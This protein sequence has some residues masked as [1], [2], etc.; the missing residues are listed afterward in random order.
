MRDENATPLAGGG[1]MGWLHKRGQYNAA[2]KLRYV[3]LY[4]GTL[5]YFVGKL[6]N[7]RGAV[8]TNDIVDVHQYHEKAQKG[9]DEAPGSSNK[10]QKQKGAAFLVETRHG[11]VYRFFAD[12]RATCD[13]WVQAIQS[14]VDASGRDFKPAQ[15]Q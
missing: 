12:S 11:R 15:V 4:G 1:V 8:P 7:E 2:W 13:T 6:L 3:A 5:F 10:G 14:A 9:P